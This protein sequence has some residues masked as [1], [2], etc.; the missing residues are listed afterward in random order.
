MG[1][2]TFQPSG[3]VQ[4]SEKDEKDADKTE[5]LVP[6]QQQHEELS[7]PVRSRKAAVGGLCCMTFG[8]VVLMSGLV[9]ASIYFYRYYY[10]NQLPRQNLFQ[11]RVL[12]EGTVYAPVRGRQ[13]LEESVEINLE[14]NYEKINVPV[15]HFGGSDAA[16]IIHDF[17]RGLTA[18][19]DITLD[20]CYVIELNTSIV[21]PPRNLRDLLANVRRGTYLP[22]TYIIQEEMV[23]VGQVYSVQQLGVFIDRLCGRKETYRLKH[24]SSRRRIEKRGAPNCHS[25]RHLENT[26]VVETLICDQA[27][28]PSQ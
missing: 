11:C 5:I 23:V 9:L 20:K 28:G 4:K 6:L 12:Y 27:K 1:K 17:H 15:P 8:S 16:D 2:I 3:V 13:E 21:M 18:Y 10:I 19:Y 14:D 25:I 24:R 7:V 22:Q 26:F